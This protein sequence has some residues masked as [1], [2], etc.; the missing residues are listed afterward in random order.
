ML[1]KAKIYANQHLLLMDQK[2]GVLI[3]PELKGKTTYGTILI[4]RIYRK[5]SNM[6]YASSRHGFD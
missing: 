1:P 2:E 6:D 3:Y 4:P 5:C